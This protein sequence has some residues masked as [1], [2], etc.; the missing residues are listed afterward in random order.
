M[1]IVDIIV[2]II[3]LIVSS[4]GVIMIFDARRIIEKRFSFNEKN[5]ATRI[6]KT[7]GLI[8]AII[9]GL[10]IMINF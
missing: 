1:N 8:I 7:L 2:K 4:I 5:S 10:I 9:G 3:G 6:L